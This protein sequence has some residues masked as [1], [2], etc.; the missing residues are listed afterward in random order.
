MQGKNYNPNFDSIQGAHPCCCR[1][2]LQAQPF[3]GGCLSRDFRITFEAMTRPQVKARRWSQRPAHGPW[4]CPGF[5]VSPRCTSTGVLQVHPF[6][7]PPQV[8]YNLQTSQRLAFR[9]FPESV[10]AISTIR[11]SC[12]GL[13]EQ[14]S[15]FSATYLLLNKH[16]RTEWIPSVPGAPYKVLGYSGEDNGQSCPHRVYSLVGQY[17]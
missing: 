5:D 13:V 4:G 10:P 9:I 12:S 17:K 7:S 6:L 3:T 14:G 2:A 1:Q 11:G 8:L 16:S 15:G